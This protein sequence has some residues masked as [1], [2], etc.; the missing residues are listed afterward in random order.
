M[1]SLKTWPISMAWRSSSLASLRGDGSP[2]VGV[3][4]VGELVD[5]EIAVEVRADVVLVAFVGAD[6]HVGHAGDVVVGPD[7][8]R[9]SS[10]RPGRRS[11]PARRSLASTIAGSASASFF[12]PTARRI[13]FS[14]AS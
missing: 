10:S 1:P 6:D 13:L 5:L 9:L 4:Q 2:A 7:R 3:A 12:A 11:R 14:F 8:H